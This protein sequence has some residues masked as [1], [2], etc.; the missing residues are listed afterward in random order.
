MI[1]KSI[2]EFTCRGRTISDVEPNV[3]RNCS[4]RS[5]MLPFM[6]HR[7]DAMLCWRSKFCLVQ[8]HF[9]TLALLPLG[10][11]TRSE[12]D[13]LNATVSQSQK[14]Y[15]WPLRPVCIV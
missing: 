2:A 13:M 14:I 5:G 6:H 7:R 10:H 1:A 15:M 12:S 4:S 8:G 3:A 11:T 9:P